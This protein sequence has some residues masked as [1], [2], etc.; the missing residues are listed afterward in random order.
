MYVQVL[1]NIVSVNQS[2]TFMFTECTRTSSYNKMCFTHCRN[3]WMLI[4]LTDNRDYNSLIPRPHLL[5]GE[6]SGALDLVTLE[7]VLGCASSAF[8][9]LGTLSSMESR[10]GAQDQENSSMSQGP[11]PH[12]GWGSGDKTK[13]TTNAQK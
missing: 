1:V 13:T 7:R 2:V 6:G 5:Q 8:M 11:S 4:Y 10:D 9:R 12:R 3:E